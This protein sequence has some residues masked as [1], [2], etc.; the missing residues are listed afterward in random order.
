[1]SIVPSVDINALIFILVIR[2]PFTA[3][4]T[5]P[6]AHV[7][8]MAGKLPVCEMQRPPNIPARDIMDPMEM[9]ISPTS[10]ATDIPKPITPTMAAD[11]CTFMKFLTEYIEGVA[12][13]P[14]NNT[15]KNNKT[16]M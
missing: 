14:T 4:R 16:K 13:P 12:I 15:N 9:S 5:P 3:P 10:M 7:I 8:K 11:R 1:M 2:I 6:I